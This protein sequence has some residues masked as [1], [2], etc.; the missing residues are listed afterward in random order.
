MLAEAIGA[1]AA[2]LLATTCAGRHAHIHLSILLVYLTSKQ[3]TVVGL[4]TL[5]ELLG[6][7]AQKLHVGLDLGRRERDERNGRLKILL[8]QLI[9]MLNRIIKFSFDRVDVNLFFAA[10]IADRE[11]LDIILVTVVS[12][13]LST[14]FLFSE[15]LL[16]QVANFILVDQ[17][18][19]IVR[20]WLLCALLVLSLEH[21][22]LL[23]G[24]LTHRRSHLA[25]GHL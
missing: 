6:E 2:E 11:V 5:A 25:H 19:G 14:T 18:L 1:V 20:V 7:L 23:A 16:L 24:L 15:F 17:R 10:I 3:V 9:P 12:A 8:D 21:D 13:R 4:F 22:F